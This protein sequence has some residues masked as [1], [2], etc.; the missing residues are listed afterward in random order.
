MKSQLFL[1]LCPLTVTVLGQSC[2]KANGGCPGRCGP[3]ADDD[4]TVCNVILYPEGEGVRPVTYPCGVSDGT[5][6]GPSTNGKKTVCATPQALCQAF[7]D[8]ETQC[9]GFLG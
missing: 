6:A 4:A 3:T 5:L 9:P 2:L 8:A 7:D 1:A